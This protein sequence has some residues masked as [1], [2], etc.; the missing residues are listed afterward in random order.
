MT[1]QIQPFSAQ[2]I[3]NP[4]WSKEANLAKKHRLMHVQLPKSTSQG[5]ARP[6]AMKHISKLGIVLAW[7]PWACIAAAQT[8]T[9]SGVVKDLTLTPV[10]TGQVSFQLKPG[11]DTTSAGQARFT[12]TTVFCEI[13][14]PS[15]TSTTS[16]GTTVTV[17]VGTAQSWQVGDVLVIVGTADAALNN[18]VA[19]AY[20]ITVVSSTTSFTFA[21]SGT[22]NNSAGGTAGGLYKSGGTGACQVAQNPAITPAKTYYNVSLWPNFSQTSG[23]NTYAIGSGPVDISTIMPTPAQMPAYSFVDLFSTQ[24]I[25]GNKTFTGNITATAGQNQITAYSFGGIPIVDGNKYTTVAAA[26]SAVVAAGGGWIHAEGCSLSTCLALGTLDVGNHRAGSIPAITIFLGP[27]DYTMTQ[28][29]MRAAFKIVGTSNGDSGG[30]GT[31]ITATSTSTPLVVGPQAGTDNAAQHCGIENLRLVGASGSTADGI[32]FDTTGIG[33]GG[34]GGVWMSQFK[35]IVVDSFGGNAVHIKGGG[36]TGTNN[37]GVNQLLDFYNLVAYRTLGGGSSVRIEG[38]NYQIF[39]WGG[40]LDS[41]YGNGNIDT[42]A[43]PN[44]YVGCSGCGAL[45]NAVV[46]YIIEFRNVTSEGAANLIQVNGAS[47]VLFDGMHHEQGYVG[48][49]ISTPSSSYVDELVTIQNTSFNG[50]V[51]SHYGAGYLVNVTT[52]QAMGVKVNHNMYFGNGVTPDHYFVSTGSA[53]ITCCDFSSNDT[54]TSAGNWPAKPLPSPSNV[55]RI[56]FVNGTQLTC[57]N[58]TLSTSPSF[59]SGASC[60]SVRGTDGLFLVNIAT[61]TSPGTNPY[62]IVGFADGTWTNEPICEYASGSTGQSWVDGGGSATAQ[63]IAYNGTPPA[64]TTI[65]VQVSCGGSP[66]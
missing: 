58:V 33:T 26:L 19:T 23:F 51:G 42:S 64:S 66:N 65:R 9:F 60:S 54:T 40:F 34:D 43:T 22:H 37:Q 6:F 38:A 2:A 53:P 1:T 45:G 10:P 46:P 12:S 48:Y 59:G 50:N 32:F 15:I 7:L 8:N 61:G 41:I 18:T 5:D 25:T 30:S 35:N 28:A 57:S 49:T 29:V 52:A 14:N 56:G 11:V 4:N 16:T 20:P 13:H 17:N 44:I 39:F 21:L 55:S 31:T 36:A 24:T 47:H 62:I 3:P 27:Y 63:T